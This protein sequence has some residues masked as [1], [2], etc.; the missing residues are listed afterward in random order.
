MKSILIIVSLLGYSFCSPGQKSL[1]KGIWKGEISSEPQQN[2]T[3][4][5][6]MK[7]PN[8]LSISLEN[9]KVLSIGEGLVGFT[10]KQKD[11]ISS[12]E[13]Y[14]IGPFFCICISKGSILECNYPNFDWTDS[15]YYFSGTDVFEYYK[16]NALPIEIILQ[17]SR[18]SNQSTKNYL[19][20]YL[21]LD[22]RYLKSKSTIFSKPHQPTKMYL[23][24]DDPVEV[25]AE[26]DGW[27][28]IKYYPEKNGE[29][30]G[31]TIEGWIRKSD[32]N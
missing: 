9:N 28:Q 29:W 7:Q 1:L 23:I 19:N 16:I 10:Y 14:A 25:V 17:L 31:K 12:E 6:I 15:S 5:D 13:L 20:Y 18:L 3:Y 2:Q 30:T 8:L 24:Q 11:T 26:K 27:L 22:F 21:D 32:V 4:Y